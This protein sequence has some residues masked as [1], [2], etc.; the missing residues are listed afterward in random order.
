VTL[1]SSRLSVPVQIV[2]TAYKTIEDVVYG[3][4]MAVCGTVFDGERVLFSEEGKFGIENLT[5]RVLPEKR[6]PLAARLKRYFEKGFDI[7]LSELDVSKL[8]TRLHKLGLS[9]V[10]ETPCITISYSSVHKNK[11]SVSAFHNVDALPKK[12]RPATVG[13]GINTIAAIFTEAE[14]GDYVAGTLRNRAYLKDREQ[15]LDD[16]GLE[17]G[18]GAFSSASA[19]SEHSILY[20][21]IQSLV[22]A[23][24]Q[25]EGADLGKIHFTL[26]GEG[27]FVRAC[28][29]A[30]PSLTPRQVENVLSSISA[31]V[32]N[33]EKLDYGLFNTY[34]KT[35]PIKAV[36]SEVASSEKDAVVATK[37]ACNSATEKQK[38]ACND[39]LP[40]IKTFYTGKLPKVL[41]PEET[42][43]YRLVTDPTLFYG[44]FRK[45]EAETGTE[46][47]GKEEE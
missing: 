45:A 27:D 10:F 29:H 2:L 26:Y 36:F 25:P 6:F 31:Q 39:L 28:L 3:A 14:D 15:F 1:Y 7:V 22:R 43:T 24:V 34:L 42:F 4:D 30:W 40:A 18:G 13:G 41:S 32:Y 33:G 5:I 44:E 37:A 47:D 11:V 38:K 20:D 12:D 21:N 16:E 17:I 19:P 46:E 23:T 35:T 8:P 9:E